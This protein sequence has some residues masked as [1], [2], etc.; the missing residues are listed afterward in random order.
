MATPVK[1]T[2]QPESVCLYAH[3]SA[4]QYNTI[5]AWLPA[6]LSLP[7]PV[8][9]WFGPIWASSSPWQWSP[10]RDVPLPPQSQGW[11]APERNRNISPSRSP[12]PQLVLAPLVIKLH[13][14]FIFFLKT[15]K[16][17]PQ[18]SPA[19]PLQRMAP[20]GFFRSNI[21]V[22]ATALLISVLR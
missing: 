12:S 18:P 19:A 14:L 10:A 22:T 3:L 13:W 9:G 4:S 1:Q 8:P 21:R 17:F 6:E 16:Y 7:T 2:S 5:A 15:E 11:G 20:L